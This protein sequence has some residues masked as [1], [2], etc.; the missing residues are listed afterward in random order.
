ML[1]TGATFVARSLLGLLAMLLLMLTAMHRGHAQT[2]FFSE[3]TYWRLEW[4]TNSGSERTIFFSLTE[5]S[6]GGGVR[7]RIL[8]IEPIPIADVRIGDDFLRIPGKT[9]TCSGAWRPPVPADDGQGVVQVV[10]STVGFIG[11]CQCSLAG[12]RIGC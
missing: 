10:Q 3:V 8:G 11:K 4:P 5:D 1:S 6:W 2:P 9:A 7:A 12:S